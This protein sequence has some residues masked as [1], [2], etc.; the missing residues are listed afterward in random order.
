MNEGW[1]KVA[2]GA[3]PDMVK[4]LEAFKTSAQ[5][6]IDV[7]NTIVGMAKTV[8]D[9]ILKVYVDLSDLEA[10]AMKAA[11]SAMRTILNDLLSDAGMYMLFVPMR[12]VDPAEWTG[13]PKFFFLGNRDS[14]GF[15][16]L[17][18]VAGPD[19]ID[20]PAGG[21]GGNYGF[22]SQVAASLQDVDDIMKPEFSDDAYV[23]GVVFY[24][25]AD[26][27]NL[28]NL[29]IL[30]KKLMRLFELPGPDLVPTDILP[31]P[32]G[33]KAT[34]VPVPLGGD[35]MMDQYTSGK[36]DFSTQ[37]YA[38]RLDWERDEKDWILKAYG[39]VQFEITK[40]TVY[41]WKDGES[42]PE[43][44][45]SG[46]AKFSDDWDSDNDRDVKRK[47]LDYE[48]LVSFFIDPKMVPGNA[49]W[50]GLS[51][52]IDQLDMDGNVILSMGPEDITSVRIEV[53]TDIKIAPR[54]GVPP[55]WFATK[56]SSIIPAFGKLIA[57]I[58]AWLDALEAS[59]VTGKDELKKFIEFL[60]AEIQRY[61][62]WINEIA[63]TMQQLIDALSWPSVYAGIWTLP[64]GKGGNN[65]F[66]SQLG[67]GLF[68]ANDPSRPP[69]DRGNEITCGF[70]MYMGSETPGA[71]EKF[72]KTIEMLFGAFAQDQQNAFLDA[73]NTLGGLK[74]R[75]DRDIC[76]TQALVEK[77]CE[78][79]PETPTS[80][81]AVLEP[82]NESPQC[83][84][85][86]LDSVQKVQF[87]DDT[88]ALTSNR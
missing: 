88:D 6:A 44:V 12:V 71:I 7:V 40:L 46:A 1:T 2:V 72:I 42:T 80:M 69:F 67:K 87:V 50:Y 4:G 51:Y 53:P 13:D 16:W 65:Y 81:N 74:D 76:L 22:Y 43:M 36:G 56:L 11:I 9:F 45:R 61:T 17:Q 82:A 35:S 58:N 83:S 39:N 21:S 84:A 28:S 54:Y 34:I 33:L 75:L 37:P 24:A 62:D 64:P 57:K 86:G 41:R 14:V 79:V 19:V 31:T 32:R 77:T 66:M 3:T 10:E 70:I 78:A 38:V 29:I 25:G 85:A 26:P 18:T 59:I 15:P 47:E 48:G 63:Y 27:A 30:A 20:R 55:D 5:A 8:A 52:S 73:V 49:Y 23:A 60:E 68:N